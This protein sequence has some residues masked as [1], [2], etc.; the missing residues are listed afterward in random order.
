MNLPLIAG[1]VLGNF[2]GAGRLGRCAAAAVYFGLGIFAA[3]SGSR[4][5]R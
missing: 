4:G 1:L 2:K 5:A 3:A